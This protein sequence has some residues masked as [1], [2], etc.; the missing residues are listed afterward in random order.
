M[1][2]TRRAAMASALGALAC[3]GLARAQAADAWPSRPI[4]LVVA[5]PPG[6]STDIV[7][8]LTAQYLQNALGVAV[9]VD[10]RG[11]AS[12]GLGTAGAARS[13]ADGYTLTVSGVGTHGVV[14][15]VNP[16]QTE[17]DPVKDF[18]HVGMIGVFYSTLVVHPSF[19]AASL[20]DYLEAARRQPGKLN[21]ATSGSGSSNHIVAEL[22]V[23]NAGVDIVHIPYRGAGPAL[24]ALIANEV[25]SMFDSLPAVAPH[26]RN[27]TIRALAISSPERLG[28][29]PDIPTFKE[30]GYQEM[31]TENWFGISGPAG[32]PQPIVDRIARA[33]SE[34]L[35]DPA[36]KA[37]YSEAGLDTKVM[38]PAPFKDYIADAF[39][40][41][42]SA[43]QRTGVTSH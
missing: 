18:T 3:P 20:T 38:P 28:T 8:R 29:F 12:G 33:M 21:Y 37:R 22:L 30:L 4:R 7:G 5:F 10:N 31:V 6:G 36:I 14:P 27:G 41:W 17:Y 39:D 19:A 16:A 43:V 15:A 25:P 34:F 35:V 11:G 26:I 1:R 40:F 13:P 24:Q 2:V 32:M 42:K 23:K 9:V